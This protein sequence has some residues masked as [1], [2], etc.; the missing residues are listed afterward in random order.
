MHQVFIA[1][2]NPGLLELRPGTIVE[3]L[4]DECVHCG[5][6]LFSADD[7]HFEEDEIEDDAAEGDAEAAPA[8]PQQPPPLLLP[9]PRQ[10]VDQ[11]SARNGPEK[12][13]ETQCVDHREQAT[14][15]E[16][17]FA[18]L[19]P[20]CNHCNDETD[21]LAAVS[22][23][24]LGKRKRH[25]GYLAIQWIDTT[26]D[27]VVW[28]RNSSE[29]RDDASRVVHRKVPRY[30]VKILEQTEASRA[31]LKKL[32]EDPFRVEDSKASRLMNS[33]LCSPANGE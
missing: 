16:V 15:S 14:P 4:P 21:G 22:F 24:E 28:Q 13:E 2:K 17:P 30:R 3:L 29:K 20:R 33:A 5:K 8:D 19:D 6:V 1:T 9:L 11:G 32:E 25:V 7:E 18:I 10:D 27:V 23:A 26:F 31:A 12:A